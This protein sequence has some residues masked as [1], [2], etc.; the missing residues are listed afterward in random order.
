MK[1]ITTSSTDRIGILLLGGA[2]RLT[3]ARCLIRAAAEYGL[4][5]RLTSYELSTEEP[6]AAVAEVVR[7][8][9]WRDPEV[10]GDIERIIRERE[11]SILLPFVDGAI[12]IAATIASRNPGLYC[13][14][15]SPDMARALFDKTV[16]AEL[17]ETNGIDIPSTFHPGADPSFPMIAK[18]RCGSASAGIRILRNASDLAMLQDPDDYLIQEYI[19]DAEEYTVDCFV[20]ADGSTGVFSPRKRLVTLGGEVIRTVTADIPELVREAGVTSG[21]LRLRGAFTIQYLHKDGRFMLMEINPRLGG[22]ATAS[23]AAGADIPA[24]IME[25]ATGRP[26]IAR[27]PAPGVMTA[28]CFQDVSFNN[29]KIIQQI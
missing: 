6:I 8:L 24:M 17:F 26:V 12:D 11:I 21:K 2:K 5:A 3:M 27:N 23:V 1:G 4:E 29:G 20:T 14:V 25:E 22:G 19:E 15:C 18:P 28:R 9:R 16:S 10:I 7:G 13:P